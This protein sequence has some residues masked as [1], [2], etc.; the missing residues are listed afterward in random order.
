MSLSSGGTLSGTPTASGSYSFAVRATDSSPAP[1]PYASAP[2]SYSLQVEAPTITFTPATLPSGVGGVAYSQAFSA[3][4]G[5]APFTFAVT[6]GNLPAGLSLAT[7]GALAGTPDETGSFSVEVTATDA[8]GF[9]GSATYALIISAPVPTV[10]NRAVDLP[11]GSTARVDLTQDSTGVPITAATVLANSNPSAGSAHTEDSGG[12]VF[13]LIYTAHPD[14]SGSVAI[15]YSLSNRWGASAPATVTFNIIARPDPSEDHEVIGLIN[16]QLDS[17]RRLARA[18]I[19]NFNGRLEQLHNERDRRN[20]SVNLQ[21]GTDGGTEP[22]GYADNDESGG[23]QVNLSYGY[24]AGAANALAATTGPGPGAFPAPSNA[25]FWAGGFVNFG[26]RDNGSIDFDQTLI[27]FSAGVDYRFS[28]TFVGGV[29]V[30][31]GRDVTDI[32]LNGTESTVRGLSAATYGSYKAADQFFIDGLLGYNRLDL[33]SRRFVTGPGGFAEGQRA[34]QQIF[35]SLAAAYDYR[36]QGVLISPYG[37]VEASWTRLDDFTETGAEGF[38][39]A[40]GQQDMSTV[41]GVLG[42]RT[43]YAMPMDWGLF[44]PRLRVEYTHDFEGASRASLSY[45]ALLDGLRYGLDAEAFGRD[46]LGISLGF[47]AGFENGLLLDL[48]YGAARAFNGYATAHALGL[49]I[50]SRF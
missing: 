28:P 13:E 43:E 18:Q 46:S 49:R 26:T 37:R 22:L 34:G 16:A 41:A 44:T 45:A 6:V 1:G 14:A 50:G 23:N 5:S 17:A 47:E 20:N 29:G 32:G 27:G 42:L 8:H 39:L 40:Y 48:E 24:A 38:N 25:A 21:V 36:Q 4:G 31:F 30:G 11:P 10:K 7:D 3:T 15:S 35:G 33:D 9:T 12:G 19:D 2:V